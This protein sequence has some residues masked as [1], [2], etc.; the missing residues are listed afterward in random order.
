MLSLPSLSHFIH[1]HKDRKKLSKIIKHL[2][3]GKKLGEGALMKIK[4]GKG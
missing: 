3:I 4:G 1:Y 2:T